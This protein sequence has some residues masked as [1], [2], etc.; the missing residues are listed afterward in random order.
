MNINRKTNMGLNVSKSTMRL[1]S[2]L[3]MFV[4]LFA[5]CIPSYAA[6]TATTATITT[7][8]EDTITI[9]LTV[10]STKLNINGTIIKIEQ[11]YITGKT[12]YIPLQAVLEAIGA[13]YI[14]KASN[15][16]AV[17]YMEN[18]AE[19]TIGS[20]ILL[21]NGAKATLS[22]APVMK[23][24]ILKPEVVKKIYSSYKKAG[25]DVIQTNTFTG[26]RIHLEKH[27]LG[28]KVYEINYQGARLAKEVMGEDGY[29]AAS[30]A[31]SGVLFEPSGE[32]TFEKAYE[33]YKEQVKAL[34]DGGVDII[35]FETFTDIAEMRA[36]LLAAKEV[37]NLPIICSM[38]FEYLV[39]SLKR[40]AS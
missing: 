4:M 16:V 26:S 23:N 39:L 29:V 12:L 38:A 6:T 8:S 7:A 5:M 18:S 27:S 3:I 11:P 33:L 35:N 13:D 31:P 20:K 34:V 10:G 14:V 21:L 28:N 15:K 30:I 17:S 19:I 40:T 37:T 2:I 24:K 36:A 22:V 1:F 25:A 32:M 9:K